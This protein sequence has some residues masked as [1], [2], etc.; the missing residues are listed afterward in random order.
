MNSI[1]LQNYFLTTPQIPITVSIRQQAEIFVTVVDELHN[2]WNVLSYE[3]SGLF[4]IAEHARVVICVLLLDAAKKSTI[5]GPIHL[6]RAVS[7]M[8]IAQVTNFRLS[9]KSINQ[10]K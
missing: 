4:S 5:D 2:D 10:G 9:K 8:N 3:K 7:S 6:A 1:D